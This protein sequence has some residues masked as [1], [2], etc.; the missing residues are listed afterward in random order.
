MTEESGLLQKREELKR[1]LSA[2]EYD[3]W[4]S[5]PLSEISPL[6]HCAFS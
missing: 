3:I 1:Q 2:G 6:Q 5:V 4:H